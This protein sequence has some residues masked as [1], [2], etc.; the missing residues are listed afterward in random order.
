MTS[1]VMITHCFIIRHCK[2]MTEHFLKINCIVKY[3]FLFIVY[4]L[5]FS[6]RKMNRK[7]LEEEGFED[8]K[9][10]YY[11]FVITGFLL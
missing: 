7:V 9:V 1:Y 8:I 6:I 11:R 10:R 2:K 4:N 3:P 5:L